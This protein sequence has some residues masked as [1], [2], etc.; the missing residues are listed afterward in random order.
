MAT[1]WAVSE[2]ETRHHLR[3]QHR[4]TADNPGH[5]ADIELWKH[6]SALA[7]GVDEPC[8]VGNEVG[9]QGPPLRPGLNK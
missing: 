3:H 2:R 4:D 1:V 5:P 7:P 8:E 6:V 9:V